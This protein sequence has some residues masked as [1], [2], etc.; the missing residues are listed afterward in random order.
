MSTQRLVAKAEQPA[1]RLVVIDPGKK[2]GDGTLQEWAQQSLGYDKRVEGQ[3][4]GPIQRALV[5]LVWEP[6]I[7][8]WIGSIRDVFADLPR[9]LNEIREAGGNVTDVQ[10]KSPDLH[11]VFMELTGRNLRE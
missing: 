2:V 4:D 6:R 9:I 8:R 11:A 10:V 3:I 5:N 7:E 1:D